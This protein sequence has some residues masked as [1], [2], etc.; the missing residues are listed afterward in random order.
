MPKDVVILIT[1]STL[2]LLQ[3]KVVE[4]GRHADLLASPS[5]LYYEMWH[6]QSSK[7]LNN[8]NNPNWE[9]RNNRMSKED[10]RKK[11]EEEIINSVKGCGNC[12]C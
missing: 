4:R 5:N 10:E 11:L 7:V 12:S 8:H 9:E 1:D 6:T 3:G 2:L